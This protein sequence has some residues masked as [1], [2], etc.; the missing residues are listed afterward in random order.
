MN[1]HFNHYPGRPPLI[2]TALAR[3]VWK[4]GRRK[5]R[6]S[7]GESRA[8]LKSH[9]NE[10]H[11]RLIYCCSVFCRNGYVM[12]RCQCVR[13]GWFA[14]C[15]AARLVILPVAGS[16]CKYS[17]IMYVYNH[18]CINSFLSNS[19]ALCIWQTFLCFW[20]WSHDLCVANSMHYWVCTDVF[21]NNSLCSSVQFTL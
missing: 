7:F 11:N 18:A 17:T 15:H 6:Y 14:W 9:A 12:P 5:A 19:D 21:F 16:D 2:F 20:D 8:L 13:L 4:W 1:A 10:P 3:E